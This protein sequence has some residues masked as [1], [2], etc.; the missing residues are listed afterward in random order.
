M[1]LRDRLMK[2]KIEANQELGII[3]KQNCWYEEGNKIKC[4]DF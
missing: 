2:L 4:K 1:D 3:L